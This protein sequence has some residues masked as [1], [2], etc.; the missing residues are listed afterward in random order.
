MTSVFP[1]GLCPSFL[2]QKGRALSSGVRDCSRVRRHHRLGNAVTPKPNPILVYD[3]GLTSEIWVPG[4]PPVNLERK[5][6]RIC[7]Y[8]GRYNDGADI[9][10]L[11]AEFGGDPALSL[12]ADQYDF[13]VSS[14]CF[15]RLHH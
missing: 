7:V 10:R 11:D 15:V 13:L 6:Y 14:Q 12:S 5:I 8:K 2:P 4:N 9:F 1:V 3:A